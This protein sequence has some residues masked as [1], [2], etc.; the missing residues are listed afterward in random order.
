MRK[1][2]SGLLITV[3]LAGYLVSIA[4][5]ILADNDETTSAPT[6]PCS[7]IFSDWADTGDTHT[8]TCTICGVVHSV[9]HAWMDDTVTLQPTCGTE[10]KK[11]VICRVCGTTRE[12][13]VPPM[14]NHT[15]TDLSPVSDFGHSGTCSVCGLAASQPHTWDEGVVTQA[16]TCKDPGQQTLTCTG[17][18]H[19]KVETMQPNGI[20]TFDSLTP[21]DG[22]NHIGTCTVC[23]Q[24]ASQA[25]SWDEGV[26]KTPATCLDEGEMVYTCIGCHYT[27]T[28]KLVI[29]TTH[30]WTGWQN[31]DE[32]IHKRICTVCQIEESGEHS[33]GSDW[34]HTSELH[35]HE[36]SVCHSQKNVKEHFPGP[37]ATETDPQI[38]LICQYVIV[39]A[40][41]HDHEYAD[42]WTTDEDGHWYTCSE[43][44]EKGEYAAHDFENDCDPDC[45][46]CGFEREIHH[47]YGEQWVSDNE[48][49]Y[50]QCSVC[51]DIQDEA[52]HS[53]SDKPCSVCGH[54]PSA[55]SQQAS[56]G[57]NNSKKSLPVWG[58]LVIAGVAALLI[59]IIS[60]FQREF[61]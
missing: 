41:N 43:C 14:G 26:V 37:E 48:K 5:P 31:I 51:G 16:P 59:P 53:P 12:E 6:E 60:F 4:L 50:H 40:L 8:Q 28:E 27:R 45:S 47:E 32:E 34:A 46:V 19:S 23:G 57:K 55:N 21:V 22:A 39:P 7:H 17:C 29:L 35:F 56:S 9:N 10:G 18:Q 1:V 52:P 36:C 20:H 44:E 30:A 13:T 11:T 25:H 15:L 54:E 2:L 33:Y 61:E 38:C 49:H 58:A 3:L 42:Q 24:E